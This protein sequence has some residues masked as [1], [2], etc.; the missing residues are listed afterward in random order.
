MEIY[1]DY[2]RELLAINPK[3][4]PDLL[5]KAYTTAD[6]FH[7]EQKRRSGEPYII[8]PKAVGIILADLGMDSVTVA[9]GLLHDVVEDTPYTLQ[10]L[11][12]DFGNEIAELVDG[13]TKL[14]NINFETREENQAEN[15]RKLLLAMSKNIRVLVIKLSDRLH[16]MRTLQ[17]MPSEKKK[18]KSRETL[19]IYAPLAARLGIYAFKFEM[20]DLAFKNLDP[21]GYEKLDAQM[22]ERKVKSQQMIEDVTAELKEMLDESGI[23]YQI[24]GRTKQY[25]SIYK[26]MIYQKKHLDEIFDLTGLRVIVNDVRDCYAV[27]GA[28]HTRWTPI[29]GRFKDYIAMP[30]PNKYQSLHTTLLGKE[31]LPF[32]IQIRTAEMHRVAEYGIAAHWKYKEGIS[33]EEDEAKLAW[34]RESLEWNTEARDSREFVDT[35]KMELFSNQVFVFTPKGDIIELPAGSTPLDFAFKVHTAVGLKCVG[36]KVNGKMVPLEYVLK[37]GEI[38][39]IITSA[40]SPGPSIDWLKIVRT[41]SAKNKIRQF[42]KKENRN[43]NTDKGR[44]LLTNTVRRRGFDVQDIMKTSF[45]AKAAREMGFTDQE[46]LFNAVSYGGVALSKTMKLLEDYYHEEIHTSLESADNNAL[47][48]KIN[49]EGKKHRSDIKGISV[50]GVDAL[51]VRFAKCC[52]PVPGDEIIGY[53]TKGRGVSVHRAD[54]SNILSLPQTELPRLI[55]VAW[56]LSDENALFEATIHVISADRKGLLADISKICEDMNINI[57]GVNLKTDSGVISN[58]EITMELSSNKDILKLMSRFRQVKNVKDVYRS[59]Y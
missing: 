9:A 47:V 21:E 14:T 33:A 35:L 54:C 22:Q 58:L 37:N 17:Y 30:K 55:E 15:V 28:V 20:E 45:L 29:P 40:N 11:K 19:E 34:L 23:E 13:V 25:Y 10:Q 7:K 24:Y 39:S 16:N 44:E 3:F 6:K 38:V 49:S 32:E 46:D 41:N 1:S 52:S 12:E 53:T 43:A 8:H 42:I 48:A 59:K 57:T 56:N 36:A 18:E 51:M 27:L 4:D 50:K 2:V 5:E 31:G 26:K